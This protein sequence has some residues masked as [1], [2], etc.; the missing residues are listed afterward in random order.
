MMPAGE[1]AETSPSC[2]WLACWIAAKTTSSLSAKTLVA[3][4]SAPVATVA[5]QSGPPIARLRKTA[6]NANQLVAKVSTS[7]SV[8]MRGISART[9]MFERPNS[10]LIAKNA[11]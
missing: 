10:R 4:P 6:W 11:T 2:P 5:I 8:I 9:P 1:N 3:E 7:P